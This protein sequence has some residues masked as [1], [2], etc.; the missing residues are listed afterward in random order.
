MGHAWSPSASLPRTTPGSCLLIDVRVSCMTLAARLG[1]GIRGREV[2]VLI[3]SSIESRCQRGHHPGLPEI[4]LEGS[5]AI[6]PLLLAIKYISLYWSHELS[7]PDRINPIVHPANMVLDPTPS[8]RPP[9]IFSRPP[10]CEILLHA[11]SPT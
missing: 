5:H 4:Y 3:S 6:S 7:R 11:Q 1:K 9:S 8:R 2:K 10:P